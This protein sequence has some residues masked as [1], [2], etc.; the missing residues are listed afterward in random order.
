VTLEQ[1]LS[2]P[3]RTA[4]W[5]NEPSHIIGSKQRWFKVIIKEG[6]VTLSVGMGPNELAAK[7]DVMASLP[8]KYR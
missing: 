4:I 1:W 8:K 7:A 6:D 5:F 3:G 2:K